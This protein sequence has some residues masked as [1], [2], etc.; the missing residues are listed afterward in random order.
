MLNDAAVVEGSTVDLDE[1]EAAARQA[2]ID[3][4]VAEAV[5][6][7]AEVGEGSPRGNP[8]GP[9]QVGETVA[10]VLD[11][12]DIDALAATGA[13]FKDLA[14]GDVFLATVTAVNADGT[15]VLAVTIDDDRQIAAA[16]VAVID[17]PMEVDHPHFGS[18]Y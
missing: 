1:L 7:S 9:L 12:R 8:G 18:C 6:I 3:A 11:G 16:P 17:P 15:G 5:A 13:R 14:G 4:L 2:R 10:Y